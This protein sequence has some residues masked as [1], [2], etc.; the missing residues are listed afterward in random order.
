MV[1]ESLEQK[2]QVKTPTM[3]KMGRVIKPRSGDILVNK[4]K[5]KQPFWEKRAKLK[6]MCCKTEVKRFL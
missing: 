3:S 5:N 1:F 2:S 4:Q 6:F